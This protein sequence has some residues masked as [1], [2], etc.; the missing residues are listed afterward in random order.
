MSILAAGLVLFVLVHIFTATPSLRGL[1]ARPGKENLYRG[2]FA[3]VV[4]TAIAIII[5]GKAVAPFEPVWEPP[6]WGRHMA[7]LLVF[8]AFILFATAHGP[9]KL[10]HY[11][12][13]PMLIGV[14]IWALAHLL[15]NGDL[16]SIMLFGT[17]AAFS[18]LMIILTGG[19]PPRKPVPEGKWSITLMQAV[20]GAA[21]YAIVLFSHPYLFGVPALLY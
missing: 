17:F 6:V 4:I 9:S 2:G 20:A 10:R 18:V 1:L 7:W 19:R 8:I 14:L 12:R 3:L 21:L 11:V 5:Y 16:A 13:H 15:A